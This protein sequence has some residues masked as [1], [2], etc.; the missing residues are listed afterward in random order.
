MTFKLL[1]FIFLYSKYSPN[2]V[3]TKS[4]IHLNRK[5]PCLKTQLSLQQGLL[6]TTK[7]ILPRYFFI[8]TSKDLVTHLTGEPKNI[9]EIA[10]GTGQVT[11]NIIKSFPEAKITATDINPG[12]LDVAKN[13]IT[14]ANITWQ[15][16]RC[17]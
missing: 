13:I 14:S 15:N 3:V 5:E 10:A 6:K 9:L 11:R 17:M 7:N 12:M 1:H 2:I 16:S 4:F 8:S